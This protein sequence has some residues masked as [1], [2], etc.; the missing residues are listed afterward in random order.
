[1]NEIENIR[2]IEREFLGDLDS[3]GKSFN[4]IKNYRTDLECFNEFLIKKQQNLGL[5]DFNLTKV[6]EY[7]HY[8]DNKYTSDN[9]RRRRVQAL[10][11]FFDY[12]VKKNFVGENP[13]R[14]IPVS[15]KF[16]DI[17]KPTS[18]GDLIKL[19][20]H[21]RAMCT[22]DKEDNL[23]KLLALRNLLIVCLIYG[24][25]L[26]VSE[27]S[28]LTRA[29]ILSDKDGYRVLIQHPKRDSYSVPL[30][31]FFQ[32]YYNNYNRIIEKLDSNLATEKFFF[33]ANA[34]RILAEG[35]SARGVELIFKEL[36]KKCEIQLTPKSLRQSCIFRWLNQKV[37]PTTIKEWMGVTP[38]YSLK[39]Y[40]DLLN[41]H[42][43]EY[44]FD[45]IPSSLLQ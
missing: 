36:R 23:E 29:Q 26:K 19:V 41:Q 18:Y 27:I 42:P 31:S 7:S 25:G 2:K 37:S 20:S 6:M 4:T 17:P 24:A 8:L 28:E 45:D 35:I 32:E 33:N 9:S 44:A 43:I 38:G 11:L 12:L 14:K 22:N 40:T 13:I 15:P 3:K 10:R 30:P 1:M 5:S 34:Y 16:L 39:A 21:L